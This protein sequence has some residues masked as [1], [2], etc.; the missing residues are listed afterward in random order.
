MNDGTAPLDVRAVS[1]GYGK[2][3]VLRD[4]SFAIHPH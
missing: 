4:V 1:V 2:R 3:L